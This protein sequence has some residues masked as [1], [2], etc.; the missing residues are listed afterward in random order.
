M[1]KTLFPLTILAIM[2][3]VSRRYLKF[4][5]D[6]IYKLLGQVI[7]DEEKHK[8][9]GATNML[10][11]ATLV[12]AFFDKEVAIYALTVL[13]VSDSF[14]ALIGKRFGKIKFAGKTLEGSMAFAISA[15][16][17]F[18]Y[19]TSYY[20]FDLELNK[21]ILAIVLATITEI[22]SKKIKLDDNLTIPL[23]ICLVML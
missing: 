8:L 23:V 10:I 9:T 17:I 12:V 2:I 22:F 5:D 16:L 15:Y 3:E 1:L 13:M 6:F 11:A 14:A 21:T 7:R 4:V 19:L 18:N 20:L